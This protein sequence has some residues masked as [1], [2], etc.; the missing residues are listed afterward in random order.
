[1]ILCAA[2][3]WPASPLWFLYIALIP[4]ALPISLIYLFLGREPFVF[5]IEEPA[6]FESIEGIQSAQCCYGA[7]GFASSCDYDFDACMAV[8]RLTLVIRKGDIAS[9]EFSMLEC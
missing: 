5:D 8:V 7:C 3:L 4:E 6:A 9:L 1:M 2:P